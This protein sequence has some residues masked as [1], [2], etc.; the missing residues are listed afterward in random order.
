MAV[1]AFDRR[2]FLAAGCACCAGT[3]AWPPCAQAVSN[4][5]TSEGLPQVLELGTQPMTRIAKTVWVSRIADGLWLH[6]TTDLITG[7]YYFPANGLI[8]ERPTGALLIDTGYRPDQVEPLLEWSQRTLARPIS[9][10]IATHFHS[11]R[12]GGIPGLRKAGIRTLAHPLTCDLARAHGTPIP[13]PIEVFSENSHRI[14]SD[15]ELY[16]PGAGH[17]RD[18]IVAWFPRQRTLFGGCM[19]KSATSNGLGAVADAVLTDWPASVGRARDAYPNAQ[20]IVPGHGAITG[21][22]IGTTLALLESVGVNEP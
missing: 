22:A 16:F 14:G 15:C 18:N 20:I 12:T 1:S 19:L 8:L 2:S 21:D 17:T 4:D 6:T 3:W 5:P 11:D 9:L 10:A 13:E 7:G